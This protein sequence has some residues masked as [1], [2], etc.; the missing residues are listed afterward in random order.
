MEH[1]VLYLVDYPKCQIEFE[2]PLEGSTNQAIRILCCMY[3]PIDTPE[4]STD[5]RD[6][7]IQI[8]VIVSG[9]EIIYHLEYAE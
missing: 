5:K 9:K 6:G 8:T 1:F 4:I 7:Y 2:S 3:S